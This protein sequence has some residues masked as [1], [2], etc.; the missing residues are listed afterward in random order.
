MLRSGFNYFL[1]TGFIIFLAM[2]ISGCGTEPQTGDQASRFQSIIDTDDR[3]ELMPGQF[4]NKST[5]NSIIT[6]LKNNIEICTGFIVDQETL[7][8]A[9][10]C[11]DPEDLMQYVFIRADQ[12]AIKVI[13]IKNRYKKADVIGL[14]IDPQKDF[15]TLGRLSKYQPLEMISRDPG[16]EK[17]MYQLNCKV[18]SRKSIA[19]GGFM[20]TCDS[21]P[22]ASGS[23]IFQGGKVVGI[24]LGTDF[25]RQVNVAVQLIAIEEIDISNTLLEVFPEKTL[26][27]C[28]VGFAVSAFSYW[29]CKA[30]IG[31]AIVACPTAT[32]GEPFSIGACASACAAAAGFCGVSV[33]IIWDTVQRCLASI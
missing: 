15:L 31:T 24:H 4:K 9:A 19:P 10:H 21:T 29:A 26:K 30:S 22:G 25:S 7:F 27:M 14:K 8:T 32:V 20:H 16:Q 12:R 33:K 5:F 2:Q 11:I 1:L 17:S 28:G 13:R 23:P 6:I 3:L 18:D